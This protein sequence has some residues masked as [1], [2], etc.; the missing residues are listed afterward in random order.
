MKKEMP[1]FNFV[2]DSMIVIAIVFIIHFGGITFLRYS[3]GMKYATDGEITK[4]EAESIVIEYA[5]IRNIFK[6]LNPYELSPLN[7]KSTVLDG[8][9]WKITTGR[10]R[11]PYFIELFKFRVHTKSGVI[12]EAYH[13]RAETG[14]D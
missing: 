2:I 12:V 6:I 13:W 3:I 9:V 10:T 14:L 5:K 7:D 11:G 4:A 8:E 1:L